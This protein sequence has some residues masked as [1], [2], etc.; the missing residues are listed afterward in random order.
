MTEAQKMEIAAVVEKHRA[1]DNVI[2]AILIG[3]L[4]RGDGREDSDVDIDLV[5]RNKR[6]NAEKTRDD[7]VLI[8]DHGNELTRWSFTDAKVLFSLDDGIESIIRMIP[9]YQ[10]DERRRKMESFASQIRMHFAYLQLAEYS[11][12]PY[13]LHE[14]AVKIAL[15]AG[16]LVLAD[17]R[18]L[19][20]NRKWFSREIQRVKEKP[21]NFYEDMCSLLGAPT[22]AKAQGFIDGLFAYKRYPEPVEGWGARFNDDSVFHWM[23]GTFSIEDW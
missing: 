14:T 2:A 6:S 10:E 13:L 23:N 22:I 9:V 19:Y 3:S 21:A 12:N 17:N 8:R 20:P 18:V 11:S 5:V 15:F 16:R 1:D 7:L 4:A